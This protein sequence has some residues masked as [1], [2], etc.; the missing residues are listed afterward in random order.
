MAV[1]FK[2]PQMC[3]CCVLYS[4][5]NW[6]FSSW[7]RS[8]LSLNCTETAVKGSVFRLCNNTVCRLHMEDSMNTLHSSGLPPMFIAAIRHA[9]FLQTQTVPCFVNNCSKCFWLERNAVSVT[10]SCWF[11]RWSLEDRSFASFFDSALSL[12]KYENS[13]CLILCRSTKVT[14]GKNSRSFEIDGCLVPS[15]VPWM[16]TLS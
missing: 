7:F 6:K 2:S 1:V 5:K 8:S 3:H 13:F 4:T 16:I 14:F 10:V 12:M 9:T 11:H 15:D